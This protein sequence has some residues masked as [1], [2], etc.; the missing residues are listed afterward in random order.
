MTKTN[1]K[2]KHSKQVKFKAALDLYKSDKTASQVSQEYG[3]HQNV[4]QRWKKQ[5]I[6]EGPEIFEDQRQKKSASDPTAQLE[7]KIGQ[8]TMELDFLKKVLGQ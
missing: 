7:R 6:E 5:L 8:L 4:L 2:K 3:V 1:L